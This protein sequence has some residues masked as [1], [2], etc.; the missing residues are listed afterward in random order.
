MQIQ[1]RTTTIDG[2]TTHYLEAGHG[3]TVVLLHGGELNGCLTDL[4]VGASHQH[5]IRRPDRPGLPQSLIGRDERH[6]DRAC[7][8][9]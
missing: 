4:A 2:L 8:D 3:D 1:S 5:H 6:T 9:Q 7:L